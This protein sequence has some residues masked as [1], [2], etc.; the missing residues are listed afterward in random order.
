MRQFVSFAMTDR[1]RH[2]G[3]CTKRIDLIELSLFYIALFDPIWNGNKI[4]T[5]SF[6]NINN[7]FV[8]KSSWVYEKSQSQGNIELL[9]HSY[10]MD[11]MYATITV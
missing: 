5:K 9:L 4:L 1:R 8:T 10:G 11:W 6:R 2:Q 7:G 3:S